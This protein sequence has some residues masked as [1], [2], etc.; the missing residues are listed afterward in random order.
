MFSR[1]V[2]QSGSPGY[3]KDTRHENGHTVKM[4]A[5]PGSALP[6]NLKEKLEGSH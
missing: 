2:W 1:V 5:L 3:A 4:A 6:G